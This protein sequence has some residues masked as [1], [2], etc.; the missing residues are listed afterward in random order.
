M[1]GKENDTAKRI[2]PENDSSFLIPSLN[3]NNTLKNR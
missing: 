3:L 2:G 1:K